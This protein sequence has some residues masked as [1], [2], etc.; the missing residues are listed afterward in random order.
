MTQCDNEICD[1]VKDRAAMGFKQVLRKPFKR[2]SDDISG[3]PALI[4]DISMRGV[5]QPQT[6]A[7]PD[8]LVID[9]DAQSYTMYLSHPVSAIL[10]S[11]EQ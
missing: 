5:W 11:A 1:A 6:V 9:T 10:L 2:E 7:L 3:I 4:T 8:V